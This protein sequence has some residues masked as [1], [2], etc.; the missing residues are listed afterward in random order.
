MKKAS[1]SKEEMAIVRSRWE[2]DKRLG[3]AWLVRDMSLPFSPQY[4]NRLAKRDA[5]KKEDGLDTAANFVAELQVTMR[6]KMVEDAIFKSALG[7]HEIK[8]Q[9]LVAGRVV[10]I[11]RKIPPSVEAQIFLLSRASS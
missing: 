4:L 1:L 11:T 6:T 2:S 9:S 7:L 3:F 8:E 5:W 10:T